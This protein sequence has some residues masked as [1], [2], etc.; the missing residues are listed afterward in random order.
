[1]AEGFRSGEIKKKKK[2][3]KKKRKKRPRRG[4]IGRCVFKVNCRLE[5][6][7]KRSGRRC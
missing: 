6:G 4:K 5:N 2:K 3:R 1:M 7:E